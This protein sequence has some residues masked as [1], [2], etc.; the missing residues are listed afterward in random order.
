MTREEW[1]SLCDGCGRCCL[2]KVI[3]DQTEELL[4]TSVAC[5]L[6]DHKTGRCQNYKRRRKLVPDCMKFTPKTLSEFLPWLPPDCAYRLLLNN[7]P[8]PK[9]HPLI[10]GSYDSVLAAG[11]S[12]RTMVLVSEDDLGDTSEWYDYIIPM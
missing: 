6:L 8:L 7:Q 2:N 5:A 9:W 11:N 12:I 10:S 1:E 4:P 3:D